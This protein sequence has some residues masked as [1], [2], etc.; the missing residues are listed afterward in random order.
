ME[1][2]ISTTGKNLPEAKP[3]EEEKQLEELLSK[4]LPR[5]LLGGSKAG[6]KFLNSDALF[7]HR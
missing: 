1:S 6:R 3:S 5:K 4:L 7:F 2:L